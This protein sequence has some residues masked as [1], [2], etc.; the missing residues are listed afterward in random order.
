MPAVATIVRV[1]GIVIVHSDND[2]GADP[3]G[4]EGPLWRWWEWR[5]SCFGEV[6]DVSGGWSWVVWSW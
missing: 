5:G 6:D 3:G 2:G 4:D 1:G